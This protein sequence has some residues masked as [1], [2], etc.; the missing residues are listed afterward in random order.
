MWLIIFAAWAL[1][2]NAAT[3]RDNFFSPETQKTWGT[4]NLITNLD[5]RIFVIGLLVI[6]LLMVLEGA[7]RAHVKTVAKQDKLHATQISNLKKGYEKKVKDLRARLDVFKPKLIFEVERC[8]QCRVTFRQYPFDPPDGEPK[9]LDYYVVNAHVKIHFDNDD[10]IELR[11]QRRMTV[12]LFRRT[13]REKEK[14]IPLHP[15]I[16]SLL[17]V[18]G[19]GSPVTPKLEDLTFAPLKK[20]KTLLLFCGVGIST[21]YGKRLNR[22][23]FIRLTMEAIRQ[24]PCYVDLDV[25]WEAAKTEKGSAITPRTSARCQAHK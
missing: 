20:S 22:D 4:I 21:R 12:S 6:A 7:Y 8:P 17:M 1:F 5:W 2:S 3:L 15:E 11:L 19:E 14:E 9:E 18:A 13:G 25:D 23:C 10:E 24:L 16:E